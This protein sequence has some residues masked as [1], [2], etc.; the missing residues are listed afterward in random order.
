MIAS[1]LLLLIAAQAQAP[2]EVTVTVVRTVTIETPAGPITTDSPN[3]VRVRSFE[4][5]R[6][7]IVEINF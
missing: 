5:G 4:K 6:Y 2:L 3:P 1:L 7:R